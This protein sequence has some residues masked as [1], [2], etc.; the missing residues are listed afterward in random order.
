MTF[1]IVGSERAPGL[2]DE[3]SAAIVVPGALSSSSNEAAL[4]RILARH[5]AAL[6]GQPYLHHLPGRLRL[7]AEGLKR[8]PALLEAVRSELAAVPGVSSAAANPLTGGIIVHYDPLVLASD[9]LTTLLEYCSP[10]RCDG[11][12]P[13]WGE[14][15][16]TRLAEWLVEKLAVA[17]IAAIV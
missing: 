13:S 4:L 3:R 8:N 14:Q 1:A 9:A 12:I 7:K 10:A 16:G 11:I 15:V 6:G 17:L 2:L 5:R